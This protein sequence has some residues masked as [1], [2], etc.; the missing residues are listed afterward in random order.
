MKEKIILA[1]FIGAISLLSPQFALAAA[2]EFGTV[3]EGLSIPGG[4]ALGDT[5]ARVEATYGVPDTCQ[6]Q[7]VHDSE[8]RGYD[9]ICDFDVIGGGQVTLYFKDYDGGLADG[10]PDDITYFMRWTH[11]ADGWVTSAGV[12]TTLADEEPEAAAAAYPDAEVLRFQW[13]SIWQI[14]DYWQGIKILRSPNIYAGTVTVYMSIFH[15]TAPPPP[16]PP[17]EKKVRVS[18]INLS[19]VKRT[20]EAEVRVLDDRGWSASGALIEAT[21]TLPDGSTRIVNATTEYGGWARLDLN[22][23]RRGQYTLMIDNVTLDDHSFDPGN[24]V[25][26]ASI[27]K[28][29]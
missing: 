14:T 6:D 9:A 2:P 1:L 7:A 26:S 5:R 19:I 13:G 22:K 27:V 8:D 11:A 25:L 20:V 28:Q 12:N 4:I 10:A 17:R 16:P 21:W 3:V 15:P 24:S 23:A 18:D 29:K